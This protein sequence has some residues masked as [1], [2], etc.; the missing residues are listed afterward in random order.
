[1]AYCRPLDIQTHIGFKTL[2]ELSN[3]T[4][5]AT[6]PDFTVVSDLIEHASTT[7]DA[8]ISGVYTVPFNPVPKIIN[9]IATDIACYLCFM[10]R[11]TEMDVPKFW[12]QE[13]KD[14]IQMVK[15]IA[16]LK[17]TLDTEPAVMSKEAEIVAPAQRVNFDDEN[18]PM[19]WF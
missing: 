16:D 19:S 6:A 17:I 1:M 18:N 10:R 15:D 5:N 13:Y 2:T 11:F 9:L 12:V 7:I 8:Y 14:A 3:D 4:P